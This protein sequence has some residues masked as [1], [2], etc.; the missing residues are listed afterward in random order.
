[1][2]RHHGASP[3]SAPSAGIRTEGLCRTCV[4]PAAAIPGEISDSS[5]TN[6]SPEF[7]TAVDSS[8]RMGERLFYLLLWYCPNQSAHTIPRFVLNQIRVPVVHRRGKPARA[9]DGAAV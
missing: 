6:C 5:P 3:P 7:G 1:V 2:L 4:K 8:Q 9:G